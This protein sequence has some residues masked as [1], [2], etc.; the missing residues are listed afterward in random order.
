MMAAKEQSPSP[1]PVGWASAHAV[2][3]AWAEA[4]P[5]EPPPI[6]VTTDSVVLDACG[7]WTNLAAEI[8]TRQLPNAP[9]INLAHS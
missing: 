2:S 5:T 8:I 6:V 7:Q 4:H 3:A 9:V 1:E